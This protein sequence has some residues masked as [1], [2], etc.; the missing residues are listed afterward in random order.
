MF[1]KRFIV[2]SSNVQLSLHDQP[3]TNPSQRLLSSAFFTIFSFLSAQFLQII[4]V[5]SSSSANC[6]PARISRSKQA[7]VFS[8][9]VD[10]SSSVIVF[11]TT[12]LGQRIQF[13]L[14][15]KE[16]PRFA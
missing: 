3:S 11:F 13:A 1:R 8:P 9:W 16:K 12:S 10:Q 6:C 2:Y 4:F 15:S 14:S 7:N 5:V